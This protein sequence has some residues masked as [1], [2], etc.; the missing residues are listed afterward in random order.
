VLAAAAIA[1][2]QR[3]AETIEHGAVGAALGGV[4]VGLGA[5]LFAGSLDD[6]HD[7]WWY[8]LPLGIACAALAQ[9]ATRGL[10]A[11]VR[12][13][14]D[15]AVRAGLP[16]YAEGVAL[17]TALATILFPPLA[18]VVLGFLAWLLIGSRRRAGEKYAG[19][20]ILR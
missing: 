17:M 4:A 12:A 7:T 1:L 19:L 9:A 6:R 11:R 18:I 10:L 3:G 15:A 16:M 8:G 2:E 5:L 14:G 13:R 20:R